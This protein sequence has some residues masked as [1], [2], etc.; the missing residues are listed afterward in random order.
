MNLLPCTR[1]F[2]LVL[3]MSGTTWAAVE[4]ATFPPEQI[5]FFEK[6]I[7]PVL[8]ESCF[9]CHSTTGEKVKGGL[10][11][12][13]RASL[14]KGGDSGPAVTPGNPDG[15]LLIQAIRY[16]D[17]DMEMP[18]KKPLTPEQVRDLEE[19][20]RMGLPDPRSAGV[21][22]K[23]GIDLEKAKGFWSFA[24]V[25][26]SALP[27]VRDAEWVRN[28][29]DRFI[30]ATLESRGFQ[31]N[32]DLNKRALIRRATFDLIGLPP[33]PEE[34]D[35]FLADESPGA[36]LKVVD[37]LLE[38]PR[39]GERWGRHWLDVV[40]YA[41]TS[42]CNSD[43]PIPS[44]HRFRDYVI[45]SFNRDKP[46]DQFLREQIAGDLLP[47]ESEEKRHEQIVATGYLAISRRFGSRNN[48][49]HLTIDDTIDNLGKAMLGLS[50]SCA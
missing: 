38:S 9:K 19:W 10:V 11:L 33:T 3:C 30:L 39:Y 36:F 34:I 26:D 18:P 16:K 17:A 41:D 45:E 4:S 50:V 35:A 7:R 5:E 44:V 29:V 49:F 22:A 20:V 12:D 1:L 47:A 2:I 25:R 8:S 14:L 23:A 40:R 37:R 42:G 27:A 46:Y 6:K 15:S 28:D 24:P 48:E 32:P 13:S 21:E 43:F 31:P